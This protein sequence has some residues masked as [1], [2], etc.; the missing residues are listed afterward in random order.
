MLIMCNAGAITFWWLQ[1]HRI[2][3]SQI[4]TLSMSEKYGIL[5]NQLCKGDGSTCTVH[6]KLKFVCGQNFCNKVQKFWHMKFKG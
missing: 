5:I 1:T 2:N 4:I 6:D 3:K